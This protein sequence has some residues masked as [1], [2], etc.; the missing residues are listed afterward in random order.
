MEVSGAVKRAD[1]QLY[2]E[3]SV[4]NQGQVPIDGLMIQ[5][6]KSFFG[7]SPMSP[8]VQLAPSPVPPGGVARGTVPLVV[9]S[10]MV[11]PPGTPPSLS[12]QIAMKHNASNG[13]VYYLTDNLQMAS[14]FVEDGS[15]EKSAFLEQWRSIPDAQE[16]SATFPNAFVP[17]GDALVAKLRARNVFFLARRPAGDGSLP[18]QEAFYFCAR[19]ASHHGH[20]LFELSCREGAP[21]IKACVRCAAAEVGPLALGC[22]ESL[23][24]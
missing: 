2:Y 14:L 9:N 21:G 17:N 12:L 16:Q 15:M 3:L 18:G 7:L 8:A 1:G 5:L 11:S 10:A 4:S 19:L 13:Q 22:L 24:A 20:V 6:N 23:L